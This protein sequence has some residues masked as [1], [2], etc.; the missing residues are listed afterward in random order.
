MTHFKEPNIKVPLVNPVVKL[1]I[2]HVIHVILDSSVMSKELLGDQNFT[3]YPSLDQG[4]LCSSAVK[5]KFSRKFSIYHFW[6]L[7]PDFIFLHDFDL[8]H[9]VPYATECNELNE[10]RKFT[11]TCSNRF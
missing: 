4:S 11:P 10:T 8:I 3:P 7:A 1:I 9:C 5:F 2:R 6:E